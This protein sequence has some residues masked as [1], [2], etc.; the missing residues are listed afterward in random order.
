MGDAERSL[1]WGD[2]G[3]DWGC[4]RDVLIVLVCAPNVLKQP[5]C[6]IKSGAAQPR[7]GLVM[8]VCMVAIAGRLSQICLDSP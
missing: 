1:A 5:L 6:N 2:G 8:R 3:H 7:S 4:H